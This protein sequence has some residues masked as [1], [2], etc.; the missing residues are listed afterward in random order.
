MIEAVIFDIDGILINS[1]PFW[2][3]AEQKCFLTVGLEL[4]D[5]LCKQTT[6]MDGIGTITYWYHHKPWKDLSFAEIKKRIENDVIDQIERNG[7][8]CIGVDKILDLFIAKQFKRAVAS[9]SPLHMIE[10]VLK[11][12]NITQF[13]H[14]LQSS[15]T[16]EAGK[17][18]P[19]VYI[20]AAKR[21]NVKPDQCLAF[22][23]SING[24]KS[25]KTAGMKVVVV[26]DPHL[27]GDARF[28]EA[29]LLIESLD[30]FSEDHLNL[31]NL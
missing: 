9:S 17:P 1:E 4:T 8:A 10:T 2:K 25:A 29:D 28:H 3:I 18:N 12:L 16:E 24:L 23:D 15:E 5:E 22:E 31:L 19:A 11:K 7:T 14:V 20:A 30:K 13:F 21:L 26:P 27:K 6:G